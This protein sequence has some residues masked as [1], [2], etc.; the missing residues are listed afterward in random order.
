VLQALVAMTVFF[1]V[2]REGGW[3]YGDMPARSDFLYLQATTA[4]LAAIVTGQVVNAF[5]CRHPEEPA[6]PF[7]P[8]DNP[9]LVA[10]IAFEI[11]LILAIVYTPP[12]NAAFGTRPLAAQPWLLMIALALG[13]GVLE[14]LRKRLRYRPA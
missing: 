6:M 11:L 4:C 10:G 7:R 13:V 3:Q 8:R 12:G 5:L 9:L 2:L 14:E 1:V